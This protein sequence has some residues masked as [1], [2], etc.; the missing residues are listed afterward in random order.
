MKGQEKNPVHAVI[1]IHGIKTRGEWQKDLAPTLALAG[2]IPYGLDYGYFPAFRLLLGKSLDKQV[3]W[4]VKE[5]DKIRYESGCER[6]SIIAHSFGTL[7]VAYLLQKYDHVLFNQVIL[8]ASIIPPNYK[9]SDMLNAQRVTW[10][11]NNFSGKDICVKAGTYLV[12]YAGNSGA[13]GF[14][15]KHRALH[16]IDHPYHNHSDYFSKGNFQCNWVPTLLLNKRIIIDNLYSI[17]CIASKLVGLEQDKL[18]CFFLQIDVVTKCLKILPGLHLGNTSQQEVS[19][20]VPLDL[21]RASVLAFQE[22]REC[23]EFSNDIQALR[24]GFGSSL[25]LHD[26]LKWLIA[27]PIPLPDFSKAGGVL[28]ID[29]L[30]DLPNG[31]VPFSFLNDDNIIK[32]LIRIGA[33]C[34][35]NIED[36]LWKPTKTQKLL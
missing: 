7:Q 8:V 31:N 28:I 21:M 6:P 14:N 26:D 35:T 30:I 12:P 16:Q 9:W 19:V 4:L 17:I 13:S 29:G 32:I 20:A 36:T 25:P 24:V 23:W 33:L 18:R 22:M 34:V 5:Y 2:L 10:V 11:V 1:S 15:D 27:L 3:N